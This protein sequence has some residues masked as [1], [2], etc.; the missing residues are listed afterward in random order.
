MLVLNTFFFFGGSDV[1]FSNILYFL[2]GK[3]EVVDLHV[4][5]VGAHAN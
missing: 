4:G 2:L 5:E 3:Q 1:L